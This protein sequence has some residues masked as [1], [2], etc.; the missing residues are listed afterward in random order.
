MTPRSP[1]LRRSTSGSASD[2]AEAARKL[3]HRELVKRSY[4]QKLDVL[5]QLRQQERSLS[6]QHS[7][8]LRY[9]Q[10][11]PPVATPLG[12]PASVLALHEK[13]VQLTSEKEQQQRENAALRRVFNQ[14]VTFR[15]KIGAA[16]KA[17]ERERRR[18]GIKEEP[19]KEPDS[20]KQLIGEMKVVTE[21][22]CYKVI[23]A[24]Y[25]E[26]QDFQTSRD[27]YTANAQ[28]LGWTHRYRLDGSNLQYSISKFFPARSAQELSDRGWV[29]MTTASSYQALHS[30]DTTSNLH[31]VQVVNEDNHVLC[32]E[33]QRPGQGVIMKT[34]LL[35]SRFQTENGVMTIYRALDHDKLGFK[36]FANAKSS[37]ASSSQAQ[38]SHH[39]VVWLD[40]FAWTSFENRSDDSGVDFHFGGVMKHFS[41]DNARFW[42]MEVLLMALRWESRTV[43]PLI[44]LQPSD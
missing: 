20:E 39:R 26:V 25:T 4:Y 11:R 31:S 33:L 34:L 2:S 35:A 30:R 9:V 5:K 13:Y 37:D 7:A 1:A 40:M 12:P 29:V 22:M 43:G 15:K 41:T 10:A 44:T 36:G 8:L 14:H 3:K 27:L 38:H 21:E 18:G 16:S 24:A 32:R 42:M 6:T 17:E 19:V 23:K 28:V